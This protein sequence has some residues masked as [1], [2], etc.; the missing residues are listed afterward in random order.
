VRHKLRRRIL[1]RLL[2][3]QGEQALA[4]GRFRLSGEVHQWMYDRVSLTRLLREAGLI[5]PRQH[6][7]AGS[8]IAGWTG[9]HLDTLPGG[10]A[11]KPDLFYMEAIKP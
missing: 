5:E 1:A 11:I 7:A 8:R 6:S 2:G 4:L 3:P 9:Y 10:S